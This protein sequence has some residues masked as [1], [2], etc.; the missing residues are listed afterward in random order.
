MVWGCQVYVNIPCIEKLTPK[1]PNFLSWLRL[2]QNFRS[3]MQQSIGRRLKLAEKTVYQLLDA[4][5]KLM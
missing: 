3:K 5:M 1:W 2:L 4:H